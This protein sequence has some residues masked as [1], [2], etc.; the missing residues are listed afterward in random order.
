MIRAACQSSDGA[1]DDT[2]E[3]VNLILS[4]E[5]AWEAF[6][7]DSLLIGLEKL[8]GGVRPIAISE[9]WCRLAGV[10]ALR[11]HGR[12]IGAGLVPVQ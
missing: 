7:L 4:G 11:T 1:F 5:L 10:C 9:T 8:G 3:L 6:L 2:L 12:G